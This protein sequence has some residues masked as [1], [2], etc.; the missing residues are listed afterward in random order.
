[1]RTVSTLH[2]DHAPHQVGVAV[3]VGEAR[4]G[5]AQFDE[6]F[7]SMATHL[8]NKAVEAQVPK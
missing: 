6:L 2:R 3:V 7:K 1:M 8:Y 4:Q 5:A